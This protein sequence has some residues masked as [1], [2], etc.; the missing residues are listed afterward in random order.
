VLLDSTAKVGGVHRLL[1][2]PSSLQRRRREEDGPA[3]DPGHGA[4]DEEPADHA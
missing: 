4:P 1:L 3:H 2:S